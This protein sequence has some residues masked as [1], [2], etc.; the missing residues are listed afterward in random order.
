MTPNKQKLNSITDEEQ[1]FS[2][3]NLADLEKQGFEVEFVAVKR[4]KGCVIKQR[5]DGTRVVRFE[6]TQEQLNVTI[7]KAI[8]NLKRKK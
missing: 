5:K 2:T 7:D 1:R 8:A 4:P 6:M 3:P